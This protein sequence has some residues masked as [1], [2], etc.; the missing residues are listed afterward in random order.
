M[1][2]NKT[3]INW[4]PG[5]MAKTKRQISENLN[6]IDIIYEV[7]DSRIPYSSKMFSPNKTFFYVFFLP[8]SQRIKL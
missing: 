8:L 6:L 1:N 3:T 4:F 2:E 7:I 5:H